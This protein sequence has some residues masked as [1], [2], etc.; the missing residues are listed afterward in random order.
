M[1]MLIMLALQFTMVIFSAN[2]LKAET[3]NHKKY[4]FYNY[5][6]TLK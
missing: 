6:Q 5:L 1:V 4:G 2:Q 3:E